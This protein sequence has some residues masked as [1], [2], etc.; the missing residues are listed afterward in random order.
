MWNPLRTRDGEQFPSARQGGVLILA[1]IVLGIGGCGGYLQGA[2]EV[3]HPDLI[4]NLFGVVFFY[5]VERLSR[6]LCV[7]DSG[8]VS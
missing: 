5:R 6:R 4:T 2:I 1:G 3:T 7:P 8:N